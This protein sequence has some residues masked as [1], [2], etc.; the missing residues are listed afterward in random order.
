MEIFSSRTTVSFRLKII[1]GMRYD[2]C[3][4]TGAV[5]FFG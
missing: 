2:A 5:P 1:I 3:Y 4:D